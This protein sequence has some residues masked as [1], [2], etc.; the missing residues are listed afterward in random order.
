MTSS[1]NFKIN[2]RFEIRNASGRDA[3]IGQGGMGTVYHGLDTSTNAPVAIKLLKAD[4]TQRDPEMLNRFLREGEALRQLNHPNIVKM[5]DAVEMDGEHYL[6]MEFVPKGSLRD[7]LEKTPTLT[8]QRA[9]YISL[10]LADALTRAHR[11]SI[12]H[13]DIKPDNV[14]IAE[15]GTPRLTDFGMARMS[16][17]PHITQDDAIVGT[18]AYMSP[19]TFH[20]ED[21]DERSD[22]WAFGVMLYEMLAGKRPFDH[23]QPGALINAILTQPVSHLETHRPDVPI[24]LV[25]LVYRMLTKDRHARIN[26]A[27]LIGA[28]L[29]AIIRG[30]G[31]VVL[32]HNVAAAEDHRFDSETPVPSAPVSTSR[33]VTPNNLPTQPT[34]FVGRT[35]ELEELHKILHESANKLITLVG[36]GGIGKTRLALAFAESQLR[37]FY[38]GV[39]YVSLAGVENH[40]HIVGA[41]ADAVNYSGNRDDIDGLAESLRDKQLLLVLDNF[42]HVTAGAGIIADVL[43]VATQLK[44]VVTSRERLRL[45]GETVFE[46]DNMKVPH[47]REQSQADVLQY[48][49]AVL[50]VQSSRRMMPEFEVTDDNAHQVANVLRLVE[51]LPLGIELAA[52][53]L[54]A[55]PLEEIAT[56]IE[57][58]I[59]F[60]E[61][62]LRDVP[63][64]HRSLRAVFEYSW[65]LMTEDERNIFV[66]LSI[67]RDGFER[68]AAEKVSGASL[69]VLTNLVNKSLLQRAPSGRFYVHKLLRQYAEE[70]FDATGKFD[71]HLAHATYYSNFL[72][73]LSPV[74][75]TSKDY[76]AMDAIE[77]ELENLRLAWQFAIMSQ[78]YEALEPSINPIMY[79]YL[80][81][82][83]IREGVETFKQLTD[84]MTMCGRGTD[85]IYYRA[86][87]RQMILA[88]RLGQYETVLRE[89]RKS[90]EYFKTHDNPIEVSFA[91]NG[92]TYAAMMRGEYALANQYGIESIESIGDMLDVTCWFLAMGNYGYLQYLEGNL[93]DARITYESIL[94][95]S[96]QS[97]VDYSP[98]GLAYMQNNLG[99]VLRDIGQPQEAARL[100]RTA[101]DVF[102][103]ERNK[104]GIAFT[105]NNLAGLH[106]IQLE[107]AQARVLYEESYRLN[108]EIGDRYGLGHS[109]SALGNS[110][111]VMGEYIQAKDYF[112][113]SLALRRDLRDLRGIADSLT[114]LAQ[115]SI[116]IGEPQK[117]LEYIDE[118]VGIR[119]ELNDIGELAS[120]LA[121]KAMGVLELGR[122]DEEV[123]SLVEEAETLAQQTENIF[124]LAQAKLALGMLKIKAGDMETAESLFRTAL[125]YS[126]KSEFI[127]LA[128]LG[129]AGFGMIAEHKGN[130]KLALKVALVMSRYPNNYMN[131]VKKT[132]EELLERL[133]KRLTPGVIKETTLQTQAISWQALARELSQGV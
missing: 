32:P 114:D 80:G 55:L 105:A 27:R 100:F 128:L 12:L 23:D 9:L 93:V 35:R 106:F 68:D 29:E 77:T 33:R 63:Q 37:H 87:S 98:T 82:G 73:N 59:D 131:I 34:A 39:F 56:E 21:V 108:K 62:D 5:L 109:L 74:I 40:H 64:R 6:V 16:G 2:E 116:N 20:G 42:E 15:D 51:G 125:G 97:N 48:P 7:I 49:S 91:L 76:V 123:A 99:E 65:N 28:E 132:N 90:Y 79:Y 124:A 70:H 81:R 43:Q 38:D 72:N 130:D 17:T 71:A 44:I 101:Y 103:R 118:A 54:D 3:V 122:D 1:L 41:V 78:Q 111:M 120:A 119:R 127:G 10:D 45:R 47:P 31:G 53:W 112:S 102:K 67:F 46:V 113:Q 36:T 121:N 57:K 18:L 83:L 96:E 24:A 89:G 22:I 84:A 8:V 129:F 110:S 50:F 13:R 52:A 126:L 69:R 75:N 86:L 94:H 133:M 19:E 104:R 115:V 26:S 25:D 14:L 66:K 58:S 61:T 88:G 85:D 30:D 60:L 95:I 11:L 117:A 107:Y 92:L 4:V